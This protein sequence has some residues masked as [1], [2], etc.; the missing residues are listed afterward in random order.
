M[1]LPPDGNWAITFQVFRKALV[2]LPNGE[3]EWQLLEPVDETLW[4]SPNEE[5]Y[6]RQT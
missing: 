4:W 3:L 2:V 6:V 5:T 1:M